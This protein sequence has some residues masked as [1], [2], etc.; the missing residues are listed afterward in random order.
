MRQLGPS[1]TVTAVNATPLPGAISLG[2]TGSLISI[3]NPGGPVIIAN[4]GGAII[5]NLYGASP[6][7][8]VK[9]QWR[10]A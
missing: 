5:P 9:G 7:S 8:I 6:R 1:A 10:S 3:G 4:V 2:A